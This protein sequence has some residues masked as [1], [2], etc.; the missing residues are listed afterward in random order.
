M[1]SHFIE[2]INDYGVKSLYVNDIIPIILESKGFRIVKITDISMPVVI[3]E[4]RC[5][6]DK[7]SFEYTFLLRHRRNLMRE[8]R[9]GWVDPEL[10]PTQD[11]ETCKDLILSQ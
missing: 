5:T 10:I 6:G 11:N 4:D 7:Y 1:E 9:R 2:T 8:S 3:C